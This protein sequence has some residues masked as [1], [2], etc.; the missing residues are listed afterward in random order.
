MKNHPL[1]VSL[2]RR[3]ACLIYEGVLLFAIL[4]ITAWIFDTLTQSRHALYLRHARQVCLFIVLG[5]YFVFFWCRGGQTLAMKTWHLRVINRHQQTLTLWQAIS[6]YLAAWL[7]LLPGFALPYF[8]HLNPAV[9]ILCLL[10]N[11]LIWLI[12][13]RFDKQGRLLHEVLSNTALIRHKN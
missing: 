12:S 7:V 6:R 5:I 13:G 9:S 3:I 4:F 1:S 10:L 11:T 8:F 2:L